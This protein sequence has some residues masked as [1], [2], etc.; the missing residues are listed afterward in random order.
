MM[1]EFKI[2]RNFISED[3][4][5]ELSSKFR[6]YYNANQDVCRGDTF[7]IGTPAI[8]NF[9]PNVSLLT[10]KTNEVSKHLG[11]P[12]IPTY[13]YCRLYK[14]GDVLLRHSDRPECEVSLTVHL[15]GDYSWDIFLETEAGEEKVTLHKGDAL[16]YSGCKVSH[17]RTEYEGEYY[18]QVFL[19]YVRENGEYGD[20]F[21]DRKGG[22]YSLLKYIQVYDNILGE[23]ICDTIV[24]ESQKY[25]WEPM[26]TRANV[27]GSDYKAR[28]CDGQML[29]KPESNY[30][31]SLDEQVY[32]ATSYAINQYAQQFPSLQVSNDCGY[33][34]L[35]YMEGDYY[36]EHTDHCL[37]N[38]RS[39]SCSIALNDNYEGGEFVFFGSE[40]YTLKKGSILMFPSNFMYPH[41]IK[42]VT[43][44]TRYSIITWFI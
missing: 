13:T 8:Y 25:P 3:E 17:W 19:H 38:P 5:L 24:S 27:E 28:K 14:K 6:N 20:R 36:E 42:P 44:G 7:V 11:E 35:R 33:Q 10:N 39:V 29:L 37:N 43:K 12:V 21:F 22:N 32:N 1:F 4:A 41:E 31:K 30:S 9:S 40:K 18:N 16:M 15:D 26:K 23:D 34:I 2:I